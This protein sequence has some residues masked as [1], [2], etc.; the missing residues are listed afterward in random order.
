MYVLIAYD[1]EARRTRHF[2]KLLSRYLLQERYRSSA[3]T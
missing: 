2:S 1:V 3:A